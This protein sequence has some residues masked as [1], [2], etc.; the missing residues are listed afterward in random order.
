M[1]EFKNSYSKILI[2]RFY[3]NKRKSYV[4]KEFLGAADFCQNTDI[5]PK[6]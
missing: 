6:V 1:F 2:A 5:T 3:T 4:Q